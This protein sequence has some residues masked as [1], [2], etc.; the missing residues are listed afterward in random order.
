M[1]GDGMAHCPRNGNTSE[2]D[3]TLVHIY[4]ASWHSS[5]MFLP[6]SLVNIQ[7]CGEPY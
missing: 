1:T 7:Y 2:G 3:G 5:R 6:C 4:P